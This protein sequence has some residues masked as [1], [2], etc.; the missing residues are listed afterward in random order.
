MFS[1]IDSEK[2]YFK[3]GNTKNIKRGRRDHLTHH[4]IDRPLK[5][6]VEDGKDSQRSNVCESTKNFN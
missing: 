6:S 4:N 5:R 3:I 1:N 2:N